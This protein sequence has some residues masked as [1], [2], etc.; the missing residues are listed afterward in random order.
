MGL[1]VGTVGCEG[2]FKALGKKSVSFREPVVGEG[3]S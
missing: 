2:V 1:A 3:K